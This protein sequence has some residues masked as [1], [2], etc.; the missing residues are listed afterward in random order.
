[1]FDF[2]FFNKDIFT[3]NCMHRYFHADGFLLWCMWKKWFVALY[4]SILS[5]NT[6]LWCTV[7]QKVKNSAIINLCIGWLFLKKLSILS[8]S[9]KSG[10]K[11]RMERPWK[12]KQPPVEFFQSVGINQYKLLF[13]PLFNL[14]QRTLFYGL[15]VDE[16]KH[17][18][19]KYVYIK[20]DKLQCT[21]VLLS[22]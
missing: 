18:P 13:I 9:R 6:K 15:Y 11:I 2:N 12:T 14:H 22:I 16:T 7:S 5:Q 21:Y 1:M 20:N 19:E 3:W 4:V 8:T 10:Q 17:L